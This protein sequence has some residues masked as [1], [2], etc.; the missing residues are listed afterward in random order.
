MEVGLLPPMLAECAQLQHAFLAKVLAH[1]RWESIGCSC[2]PVAQLGKF[3]FDGEK[4]AHPQIPD[5]FQGLR[6]L[7]WGPHTGTR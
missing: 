3:G 7:T 5:Q 6:K 4:L 2:A 1:L